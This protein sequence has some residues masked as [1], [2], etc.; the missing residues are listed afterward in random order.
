MKIDQLT[1]QVPVPAG[2][3]VSVTNGLFTLKGPKGEN[4]RDLFNPKLQYAVEN[5][6]IIIT[7]SRAT[8]REK[9]IFY[10]AVSHIKNLI[11]GVNEGFIYTLKVCSGHFPMTVSVKGDQFEVKNF[12][13][14]AVPRRLKLNPKCKVV[15]DGVIIS[16]EGN[17]VEQTGQQAAMIEQLAKRVG[18]DRRIF[19]DGIYIT[20]KGEDA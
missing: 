9:T 3:T 4:A 17:D 2:V 8:K 7:C 16:V 14:E 20:S 12:I 1:E 6:A 11:K 13:G 19:Q 18:F 10:T 15:V 5:N